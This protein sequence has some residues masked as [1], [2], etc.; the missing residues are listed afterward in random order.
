MELN[1]ASAGRGVFYFTDGFVKL[2]DSRMTRGVIAHELAHDDLN[3]V[4]KKVATSLLVSAIFFVADTY[5]P[6]V[7]NL[8]RAVNPI[9]TRTDS[10]TQELEA[11][12]HAIKI[13][14]QA[15]LPEGLGTGD[16]ETEARQTVSHSLERLG[17]RY[18][19]TSVNLLSTH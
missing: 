6:G 12:A 16:A 18:G 8:D 19:V 17:D 7:G 3:H 15:Y 4:T 5:I 2:R 11:D 1:A 9:I 14:T 13:L 10:R